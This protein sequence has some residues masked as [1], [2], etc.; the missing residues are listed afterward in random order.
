MKTYLATGGAGSLGK[1]LVDKIILAGDKVRVYDINEAALA[2]LHYP[3]PQI[4]KIYGYV[5]DYT[6]LHYAMIGVDYCIHTAALKNLEVTEDNV[7]ELNRTNIMGTENVARAAK[8]C[9]VKAAVLISTDKCVQ[10]KSAYGASKLCAEHLWRWAARHQTNTRFITLRSGN[11]IKSAGNVFELWDQQFA[12]GEPLTLTD[13]A[14]KRYFIDTEK[15][16][17]IILKLAEVGENG[18]TIIPKMREDSL[19]DIAMERYPG[20]TFRTIGKR[21]GEKERESLMTDDE[22]VVSET[23]DWMVIA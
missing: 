1:I 6:R 13:K 5:Q 18:Q 15:V 9:G 17:D 12:R 3:L 21:H 14:M 19:M 22:I 20:C 2:S 4:T 10:P 16:A 23:E 8:E 7:P 11:F